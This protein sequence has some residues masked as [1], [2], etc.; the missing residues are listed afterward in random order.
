HTH[1]ASG[2]PAPPGQ[3]PLISRPRCR[4]AELQIRSVVEICINSSI[5]QRWHAATGGYFVSAALK[6]KSLL[7]GRSYRGGEQRPPQIRDYR[8][9]A[10]RHPGPPASCVSD[11]TALS[12]LAECSA[13]K[14]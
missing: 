14:L 13:A 12:R 8:A 6:E 7:D 10:I 2:R 11:P 9:R 3:G 1:R 5:N 4:R